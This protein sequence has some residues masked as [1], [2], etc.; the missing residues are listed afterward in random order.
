VRS[1]KW[2]LMTSLRGIHVSYLSCS[3]SE[4]VRLTV[5]RGVNVIREFWYSD[6]KSRL[7]SAH[8]LLVCL[9][10]DKRDGQTLRSEPPSAP[11]QE[12]DLE[13][14]KSYMMMHTQHGEDNYQHREGS[15]NSRRC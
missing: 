1:N 4:L 3:G 15:H 13:C 5:T 14:D 11:G 2:G 7:N 12:K 6:L 8:H 9:G 10:R